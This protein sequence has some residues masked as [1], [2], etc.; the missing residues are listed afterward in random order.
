MN[1]SMIEDY[2][3]TLLSLCQ[4]V[5]GGILVFFQTYDQMQRYKSKWSK[6]GILRKIKKLTHRAVIME[7]K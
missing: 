7:S 2:G 4:N 6:L 5:T 1:E 3:L